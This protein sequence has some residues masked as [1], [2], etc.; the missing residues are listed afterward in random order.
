MI[1]PIVTRVTL[2]WSVCLCVLSQSCTLLKLLVGWYKIPFKTSV[3]PSNIVWA[4]S[5]D[6][7]RPL[8]Y[9]LNHADV[10]PI[11]KL[12]WPLLVIDI[13]LEH[14]YAEQERVNRA[15]WEEYLNVSLPE[16]ADEDLVRTVYF[17]FTSRIKMFFVICWLLVCCV[18]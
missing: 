5:S 18:I 9:G 16:V 10:P 14:V 3:V 15:S 4:R 11:A 7:K 12:L 6:P 17:E 1:L 8:P 13:E 2:A